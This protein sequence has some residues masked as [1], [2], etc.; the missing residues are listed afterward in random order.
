MIT[1]DTK[2]QIKIDHKNMKVT[3]TG[4]LL[5][6]EYGVLINIAQGTVE[7]LKNIE[8]VKPPPKE[9]PLVSAEQVLDKDCPGCNAGVKKLIKGGMGWAKQLLGLDQVPAEVA[10][11]RQSICE[12]CPSNCYDFGICRDDWPDRD[13]KDQGCGCVLAL[14]VTQGKEVCPHEHW[15]AHAGN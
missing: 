3:F 6:T 10:A 9:K 11:A 5:G 13:R 4:R 14:K 8:W 2:H 15:I 7:W 1:Q 12:A